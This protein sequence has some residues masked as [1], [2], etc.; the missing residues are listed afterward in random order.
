M[1]R[2]ASRQLVLDLPHRSALGAD[3]FLVSRSNAA[4]VRLIDLW[5]DWPGPAAML[6]GPA[7]S[8]KTH[9]THVW[10]ER[11]GASSMPAAAFDENALRVLD[12][13]RAFAIEDLDRGIGEER[14]LFHLLNIAHERGLSILLTSRLAPGELSVGLPDLRSRLRALPLAAV[15][16]P[17]DPLIEAVLVK[18]F[19]DRQIHVDPALVEYVMIRIERSMAGAGRA[20]EAI[21]RLA[22]AAH[23]KVTKSLVAEALATLGSHKPD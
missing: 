19:A 6:T 7:G 10:R 15:E 18:L 2:A 8:G 9:L 23:R 22:L 12:R 17:D 1:R 21:D 16:P 3:D 20:V 5:P 11:T 14:A 13:E 4:A